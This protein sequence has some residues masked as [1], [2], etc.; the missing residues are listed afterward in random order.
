MDWLN[1][2]SPLLYMRVLG[3]YTKQSSVCLY[4]SLLVSDGFLTELAVHLTPLILFV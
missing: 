1:R 2:L 3:F 4:S